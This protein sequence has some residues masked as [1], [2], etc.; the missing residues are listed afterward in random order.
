MAIENLKK[1]LLLALLIFNVALLQS[2]PLESRLL[3]CS[4]PLILLTST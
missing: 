1:H 3:T 4:S 2:G